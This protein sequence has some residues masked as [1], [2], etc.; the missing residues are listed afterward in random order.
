MNIQQGWRHHADL[1]LPGVQNSQS[2]LSII[3]QPRQG[4][5]RLVTCRKY[6]QQRL[7]TKYNCPVRFWRDL[8]CWSITW[9]M[10]EKGKGDKWLVGQNENLKKI[11][12]IKK[13]CF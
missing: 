8:E 13:T 3:A 7:H 4:S 2:M 12:K 5:W 6:I 11:K 1:P 9:A 10:A